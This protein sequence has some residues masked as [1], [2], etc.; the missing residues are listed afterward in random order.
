MTTFSQLITDVEGK[1]SQ[2]AGVAVQ[3]YA[4]PRIANYIQDSFDS[5]FL[6]HYWPQFCDWFH[7]DLNGTDG[8]PTT[9]PTFSRFIDIRTAYITDT[10]RKLRQ[11]PRGF[12]PL[13][14]TGDKPLYI[15]GVAG[16]RVFRCWP[17]DSVGPVDIHARVYPGRFSLNSTVD[18]DRVLIT[19]HAAWKYSVDDGHNPQQADKFMQEMNTQLQ[20]LENALNFLPY[21]LDPRLERVPNNWAE[22]G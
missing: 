14:F 13:L 5:L 21:E 10:Q 19:S 11:T 4:Q 22:V 16:D 3:K 9:V 18:F 15:E 6:L 1:L 12:N 2:S 7:F 17:K 20:L 8:K